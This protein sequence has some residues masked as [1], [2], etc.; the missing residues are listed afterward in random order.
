MQTMPYPAKKT[1]K[2][3]AE[4]LERLSLGET[5][6][7]IARDL[8]FSTMSWSRWLDEDEA[9]AHAHT[10]ARLAGADAV[11]DAVLEIVDTPPERYEGRIDNGSISWARNRAE[12]R[13][14]L[15]GFWQPSKYG[16]KDNENSNKGGKDVPEIDTDEL[17]LRLGERLLATKRDAE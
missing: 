9:L 10:Q 7:S 3:V 2:L 16:N 12:Y 11:A 5:L 1:E 6:T 13:L 14:R 17:M 15:L 8:K 4:V